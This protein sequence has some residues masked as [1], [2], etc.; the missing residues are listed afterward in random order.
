MTGGR[1][2]VIGDIVRPI[3]DPITLR[4]ESGFRVSWSTTAPIDRTQTCI[5]LKTSQTGHITTGDIVEVMAPDGHTG[6]ALSRLL[7]TV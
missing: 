1:K 3:H 6:W 5:V 4:D 7:V 2:I